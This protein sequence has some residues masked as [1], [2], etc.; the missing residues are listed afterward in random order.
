MALNSREKAIIVGIKFKDEKFPLDESLEELK[1][2]ARTSGAQTIASITQT[3]EKPDSKY[4]IGTGKVEEL[5][6]LVEEKN[7]DIVIFDHEISPAQ[8]RN[9][10]DFLQTKVID[11]T[12]LILDIFALH[13]KSREGVLQVELAQAEFRLTRLV[14]FGVS[15]SRLGGG[16]GTRGPGETKL[17]MDRRQIRKK[18]S[19]LKRELEMVSKNRSILRARRK[20]SNI[21]TG[22][23]I[24]YTN[25]GKSTL[26]NSLAKSNVLAED[27]LFATLDPATKRVYLPGGLVVLLTDTVGFIQKLPHQLVDAFRAT[28]EEVKEADF[29]VHVVDSSSKYMND[30]IEAVY[31]VL[32]EMGIITK[33]IITVFN[34]VDK[35]NP[36]K[37][38]LKKFKP[39]VFVSAL[40]KTGFLE[41]SKSLL[42]LISRPV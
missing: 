30:Q 37:S 40:Y 25:S 42:K 38:L 6:N 14:G 4:F 7:A 34:K 9:L 35:A 39:A 19:E 26:L 3:R 16:I 29:L 32:E 21:L 12:E 28:L 20:A 22:A 36:E 13:A 31:K 18:I 33:P 27:K 10:E 17:E 8:I 2:L 41:L 1:Q 15:L 5:K 24:G 11:R 23:I